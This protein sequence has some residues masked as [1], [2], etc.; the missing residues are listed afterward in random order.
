MTPGRHTPDPREA[1]TPAEFLALLQALKDWSGLTYRELSARA[2]SR[3]D[4]LPRSTVANMLARPTLPRE[5]LLTVFVRACG[6]APGGLAGWLEVRSALAGRGPYA[7]A[8]PGDGDEEGADT[9]E[10][11]AADADR[12]EADAEA[13]AAR[14][15]PADADPADADPVAE[16]PA[17]AEPS[18]ASGATGSAGPG[19]SWPVAPA[20]PSGGPSRSRSETPSRLRRA[21]VAAVAVTGLLLA[22]FSV[23]ALLR[24]GR[25]GP[26]GQPPRTTAPAT[27][28][29]ATTAP[30]TSGTAPARPTAPAAGDVRI[31][32][33][34]TDLCLAE[35]RGTRTGQIHQ[36]PCAEAVVPLYSLAAVGAGRWR[37][38]S[39]HPDFG[40]GCSGIPSGGRIPDAPYEDS[41][42]GDNGRVETFA[43]EPYGPGGPV[44]GY[45]I[46]P[47]GSGTPGSCVT[48]VGDRGA[49]WA[50]LA[51]APCVPDAA[52][53][54]FS[55]DRRGPA[56]PATR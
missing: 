42:C 26:A 41:E 23:V 19:F 7:P 2:E 24:D 43:L 52:G 27:T 13:G 50:R 17:A 12:A 1:R 54:L 49:A 55:F 10:G 45:R 46:V 8:D 30:A 47:V 11:D 14:S 25:T 36:V 22:G 28:A 21:L 53:Q 31:R 44:R 15:D 34:D 6:V 56:A 40:P 51:Q 16:G 9:A 33:M 39:D 4:V 35:R 29:P 37:I 32:V 18:D 5:E 3:G 20:A 48:V 38:V